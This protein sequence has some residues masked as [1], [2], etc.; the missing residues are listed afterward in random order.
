MLSPTHSLAMV[1]ALLEQFA[2]P[3]NAAFMR[4]YTGDNFEFYGVKSYQRYKIFS[5]VADSHRD[6]S[7]E[8]LSE[9]CHCCFHER[10]KREM[11]YFINDIVCRAIHKL[12]EPF[13]ETVDELIGKLSW[14][15]TVVGFLAPRIAGPLFRKYPGQ[16]EEYTEKWIQSD[17]TWYQQAAITFQLHYRHDT[18]EDIL[19]NYIRLRAD[20]TDFY[21]KKAAGVALQ[22][23]A[24]VNPRAVKDFLEKEENLSPITKSKAKRIYDR[25]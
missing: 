7:E 11:Q 6:M 24:R 2:D 3:Y 4:K 21:V 12:E 22:H 8:E 23:Y 10:E 9:L 18:D 15:D 17:D 20:T 5:Q 13:L 25:R 14:E 1:R 19:F 16:I